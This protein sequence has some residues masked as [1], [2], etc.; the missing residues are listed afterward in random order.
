MAIQSFLTRHATLERYVVTDDLAGGQTGVW[1][2]LAPILLSLTSP[3]S[4]ISFEYKR[5]GYENVTIGQTLDAL[6]R[7][8]LGYSLLSSLLRDITL[9]KLRFVFQGRTLHPI[10]FRT[11][12]D[13]KTMGIPPIVN[14][15]LSDT[16]P[17]KG[18]VDA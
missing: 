14:L 3:N 11:P 13:G 15:H 4:R 10:A 2:A 9:T 1:T 16:I 7:R 17:K 12:M 18:Y 6:P 5:E 8:I